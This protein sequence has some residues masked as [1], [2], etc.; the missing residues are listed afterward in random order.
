MENFLLTCKDFCKIIMVKINYDK[1][2]IQTFYSFYT[3]EKKLNFEK[4]LKA[5][6]DGFRITRRILA[7]VAQI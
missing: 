2:I 7:Q 1:L 3:F 6:H 5:N 4:R